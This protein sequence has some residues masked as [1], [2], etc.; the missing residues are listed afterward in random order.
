M[1]AQR[2]P[3][4]KEPK[5]QSP[6]RIAQQQARQVRAAGTQGKPATT[7]KP[8]QAPKNQDS[9]KEKSAFAQRGERVAQVVRDTRSELRKVTWPDR[10]TTRNLT[11][12]VI[13]VSTVLGLLLGGIDFGLLKLFE[14]L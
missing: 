9:G 13:G 4:V 1:G 3:A 12:L 10:D 6:A 14:A 2:K 11:L 5:E 8:A 7:P